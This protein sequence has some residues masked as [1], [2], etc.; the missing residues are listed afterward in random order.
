MA[1]TI[2]L[3]AEYVDG[4]TRNITIGEL[5]TSAPAITNLKSNVIAFNN[6]TTRASLYPNFDTSFVSE[7]GSDFASI[8]AAEIITTTRTYYNV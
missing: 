5:A 7:S 4:T 1:S 8:A 2:K 3:T 6:P